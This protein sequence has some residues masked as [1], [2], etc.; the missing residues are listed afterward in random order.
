M[1]DDL[2]PDRLQPDHFDM[3]AARQMALDALRNSQHRLDLRG[4]ANDH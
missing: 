1:P 2:Q 4:G 3:A